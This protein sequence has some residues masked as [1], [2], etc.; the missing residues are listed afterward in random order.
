MVVTPDVPTLPFTIKKG[1]KYFELFA[2]PVKREILPGL[3]IKGWGY[4]GSIPGP[5]IQVY[6][7]DY[8]TQCPM[9]SIFSQ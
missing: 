5:T 8:L 7:G 4:N 9:N 1:V 2:E 6:S 3:F